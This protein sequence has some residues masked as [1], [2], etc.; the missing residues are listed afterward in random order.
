[1][2]LNMTKFLEKIVSNEKHIFNK[3]LNINPDKKS[4]C[5]FAGIDRVVHGEKDYLELVGR[6]II[7]N[8]LFGN[9]KKYYTEEMMTEENKRS[10]LLG[11][12]SKGQYIQNITEFKNESV[13]KFINKKGDAAEKD[14]IK[15]LNSAFNQINDNYIEEKY[16]EEDF[17]VT[18]IITDVE[19][20]YEDPTRIERFSNTPIVDKIK[21]PLKLFIECGLYIE[22]RRF[23]VIENKILNNKVW[24]EIPN[25]SIYETNKNT[26]E[27]GQRVKISKINDAINFPF[28]SSQFG[29]KNVRDVKDPEIF[30]PKKNL[31]EMILDTVII[32]EEN[33]DLDM[34][35]IQG[36]EKDFLYIEE[37]TIFQKIEQPFGNS[38]FI[39]ISM[40]GAIVDGQNSID[41][42]KI[43]IKVINAKLKKYEMKNNYNYEDLSNFENRLLDVISKKY[44]S[45][46]QIRKLKSFLEDSYIVLKITKVKNVNQA[47]TIAASKNASMLV[48]KTE[49]AASKNYEKVQAI[50]QY[51]FN[52]KNLILDYVKKENL[53]ITK[54]ILEEKGVHLNEAAIYYKIIKNM[55]PTAFEDT[56]SALKSFQEKE[57]PKSIEDLCN[58]FSINDAKPIL[59]KS[60]NYQDEKI[61]EK[62][63]LIKSLIDR[64]KDK[65]KERE[66]QIEAIKNISDCSVIKY[67]D[68]I[69]SKIELEIIEFENQIKEIDEEISYIKKTKK[70]SM[71]DYFKA[72]NTKEF[73]HIISSVLKVRKVVKKN[74]ELINN[75]TLFNLDTIPRLLFV[76]SIFKTNNDFKENSIDEKDIEKVIS[77][78]I[79]GDISF[80]NKY[81][82][83][84]I[85]AIRNS[86]DGNFT[87]NN[88]ENESYEEIRNFLIAIYLK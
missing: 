27:S 79:E 47:R 10:D 2:E 77:N 67:I 63:F 39:I 18:V 73:Y 68:T 85:T 51:L 33:N 57:T 37:D 12:V 66:Y 56:V 11:Q 22:T 32:A 60:N 36:K 17:F 53:C 86:V 75:I 38:K 20:L 50:S 19:T 5:S 44:T 58:Y 74:E 64:K 23:S 7:V 65:L 62:N 71:V 35:G 84:G 81:G 70:D 43:I 40:N 6:D 54:E 1:M 30:L 61:K 88:Q 13:T 15:T 31:V 8:T 24:Y 45:E 80:R 28:S 69:I 25:I 76:M 72:S 4:I 52:S 46:S 16:K 55:K 42:F 3:L 48:S 26:D 82:T 59:D 21:N 78:I 14:F 41:S 9:N 34:I 83:L 87:N 49:L 29:I